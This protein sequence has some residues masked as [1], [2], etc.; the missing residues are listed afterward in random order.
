MGGS[1]ACVSRAFFN[2]GTVMMK[3]ERCGGRVVAR[4]RSHWEESESWYCG[5]CGGKCWSVSAFEAARLRCRGVP[6]FRGLLACDQ[7]DA[8]EQFLKRGVLVWTQP[9]VPGQPNFGRRK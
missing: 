8:D 3:C 7:A 4:L 5:G 1:P 9:S 6:T 2:E